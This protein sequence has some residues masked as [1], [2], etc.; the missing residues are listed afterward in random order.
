M[1]VPARAPVIERSK[2]P[3]T[4]VMLTGIIIIL[5]AVASLGGLFLPGLYRDS[6]YMINQAVGQDLVTLVVAVP[7]LI[8][9]LFYVRRGSARATLAWVGLLGY[10]LYTYTTYAFGSAFNPFFL[11]YVG[12]FSLAI[13]TLVAAVSQMDPAAW[14]R[15]FD[16]ATPRRPVAIFLAFI[17]LMVMGLWLPDILRYLATGTLPPSLVLAQIPTNFVYVMDLGLVVPLAFLSAVWLWQRRPW[18]YL[19]AGFVLMKA[20]TMGLA[21]LSMV[22][23]MV[24]GG[25]ALE[26]APA[27]MAV[28]VA[29]GGLG[30]TVWFLRHCHD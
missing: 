18:G 30:F 22:W 1:A 9:T 10:I 26:V 7:A 4:A 15:R 11:I 29:T 24:R 8:V 12:L 6:Q 19:L 14:S 2:A 5:A 17:G 20:T 23:F 3:G 13:F 27:T 25:D 21:L 28:I 16:A